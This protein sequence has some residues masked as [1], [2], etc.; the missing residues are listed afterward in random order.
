MRFYHLLS[1]VFLL[2]VIL[3]PGC[4]GPTEPSKRSKIDT[5][6]VVT[7]D[8][9][10]RIDTLFL[11]G[12]DSS[13]EGSKGEI[14]TVVTRDSVFLYDTTFTSDTVYIDSDTLVFL[15][16]LVRIDS[17]VVSRVDTLVVLDTTFSYDTVRSGSDTLL[18]IDTVIRLDSMFVFDTT[19]QY[20]TLILKDSVSVFDTTHQ[21]DTLIIRD[22]L[23]IKD[24]LTVKD[25]LFRVDTVHSVDT[26]VLSKSDWATVMDSL[27]D[28]SYM[29]GIWFNQSEEMQLIGSG[30][31]VADRSIATNAHVYISTMSAYILYKQYNKDVSILAVKNGTSVTGEHAYVV[32]TGGYHMDYSDST[33]FTHDIGFFKTSTPMDK[34]IEIPDVAYLQNLRVGQDIG[35]IGYPGETANRIRHVT[36][37]TFKDGVIS[38]LFP[39]DDQAIPTAENS[40]VLQHNFNTSSGTSGS[41]IFD[42]SGN[43]VA[44]HNSGSQTSVW[45]AARETVKNISTGSIGYGIRADDYLDM[46]ATNNYYYYSNDSWVI[47]PR[48]YYYFGSRICNPDGT[49]PVYLGTTMAEAETAANSLFGVSAPNNIMSN[50]SLGYHDWNYDVMILKSELEDNVWSIWI[51]AFDHNIYGPSFSD[52]YW[53]IT[54]G[55]SRDL[56][57]DTYGYGYTSAFS[58]DSSVYYY[59]YSSLGIGFG[60]NQSDKDWKCDA[61][62]IA[63]PGTLAKSRLGKKQG[64]FANPG[65]SDRPLLDPKSTQAGN[66]PIN[67]KKRFK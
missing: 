11:V 30:F 23:V 17:V 19:H 57:R 25:T 64:S 33:V 51:S 28:A 34:W 36:H 1:L 38:A 8:T 41:P 55:S 56:I 16:T 6:Y 27:K 65:M 44:I 9:L 21:Y 54:I 59:N 42:L 66:L 32:D 62:Q 24:T 67:V 4:N 15:D 48:F 61:I 50:G 35:T 14:D 46:V 20:D 3:T 26:V 7:S 43:L 47:P 40:L 60:F 12:K 45:D 18:V 52:S 49:S 13:D 53:G 29:I 31:S 63:E 2:L 10:H 22:T 5:L 37:G 39:F 58:Q